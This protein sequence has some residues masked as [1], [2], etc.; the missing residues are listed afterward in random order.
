M[1]KDVG[2][3]AA[4]TGVAVMLTFIAGYVDA[5]GWLSLDR[6][7]TAQMSGNFVLL[8]VH[9]VAG[10][11]THMSLQA[12]AMAA[13]LLGLL[14]SGSIIEIGMRRRVRRILIGALAVEF[15]M[16]AAFAIAGGSL[17]PRDFSDG[18]RVGWPVYAAI[19]VVAFAMGTQNTSLRMAGIIS[20]FTTH[21]T[22]ALSGLSEEIIICGFSLLQPRAR[23]RAPGGFAAATLREKHPQA[24]K[25]IGQSV[26][27]LVGF[28]AGALA[29]A[30][31]L[32]IAGLLAA[33]AVPL[34]LL[35]GIGI[36]D[37]LVP[38]TQFPSAAEQE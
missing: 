29:G 6:V 9:W 30:A 11:R 7:F 31:L 12:D 24:F 16:L 37:W 8:A 22:G 3:Q 14:V 18:E 1:T 34:A 17:L 33:M 13:F 28:F 21:M 20:V 26:A 2:L 35:G 4:K 25:T 5:I 19:A 32:K 15:I 27:L 10:E 23:R 38:L 36:F